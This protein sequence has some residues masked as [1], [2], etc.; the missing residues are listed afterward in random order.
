[1]QRSTKVVIGIIITT[2]LVCLGLMGFYIGSVYREDAVAR[3]A[4][5]TL[6]LY[7]DSDVPSLESTE[8]QSTQEE[9][10]QVKDTYTKLKDE[11]VNL[12]RGTNYRKYTNINEDYV[13]TISIPCLNI[14]YPVVTNSENDSEFYLT[15]LFNKAENAS[16]TIFLDYLFNRN[17]NKNHAILFGHN[18]RDGSMFGELKSLLDTDINYPIYIFIYNEDMLSIY[19]LYSIYNAEPNDK[20]YETVFITNQQ[21]DDYVSFTC[22]KALWSYSNMEQLKPYFDNQNQILTLSTCH[23]S[24]HKEFTVWQTICIE[25]INNNEESY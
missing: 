10:K 14:K 15:H 18:M 2:I 12:W 7:V 8:V 5:S 25:R 23:G 19:Q 22:E 20:T 11:Y 13:C 9:T 21:Y 17:L 3:E 4:Y 1:M 24:D 6:N 16:G